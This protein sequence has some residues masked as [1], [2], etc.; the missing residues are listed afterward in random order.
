MKEIKYYASDDGKVESPNPEDI[1]KYEA[2]ID[3]INRGFITEFKDENNQPAI[4]L[5]VEKFGDI[6]YLHEYYHVLC[7]NV[8]DDYVGYVIKQYI[9]DK[10]CY[11]HIIT[12]EQYLEGLQK[13]IDKRQVIVDK[14]KKYR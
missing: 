7:D 6:R 9:D 10:T 1:K 3:V 2:K 14:I 13:E 8:L 12:A 5:K 4:L 11:E